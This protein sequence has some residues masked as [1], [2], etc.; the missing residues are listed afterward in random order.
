MPVY[1]QAFAPHARYRDLKLPAIWFYAYK[2]MWRY[3]IDTSYRDTFAVKMTSPPKMHTDTR[4]VRIK[5]NWQ[6]ETDHCDQCKAACCTVLQC[7]LLNENNR[8]FSYG[9]LFFAYMHCGRFP[10]NQ[11]QIEYYQCPKWESLN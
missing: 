1:K 10:E 3:L 7:P 2:I 5:A 4:L 11:K 9:S 8:C 6:D